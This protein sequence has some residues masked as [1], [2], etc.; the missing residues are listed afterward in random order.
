MILE[1]EC[2]KNSDVKKSMENKQW[3]SIGEGKEVLVQQNPIKDN[4]PSEVILINKEQQANFKPGDLIWY[5]TQWIPIVSITN[6]TVTIK[7]TEKTIELPLT[8]CKTKIQIQILVCT[9]ALLYSHIL[10]VSADEILSKL[11]KKISKKFSSKTI[12]V[13]WYYN[14]KICTVNDSIESIGIK[15]NDKIICTLFGYDIKTFKRFREI[16]PGRGWY[17]SHSSADAITFIPSKNIALFGFGMYYTF[18]GPDTYTIRYEIILDEETKLENTVV[19]SK[20]GDTEQISKVF[21]NEYQE[22]MFVSGGTKITVSVVYPTFE[23]ESRLQVGHYGNEY[24][25]LEGNEPGL[26]T[27]E[28]SSRSHNGTGSS[29]G[30][31]PELYYSLEK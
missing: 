1:E 29:S 5:S 17:M 26:F 15:N 24:D 3:V 19:I 20:R 23:N 11:G 22:P 31:I 18:S 13:D 7:T 21:L 30:Q 8:E 9:Q 14:G 16:E 6:N 25:S 27:I 12:K 4:T 2:S 10:S 28:D